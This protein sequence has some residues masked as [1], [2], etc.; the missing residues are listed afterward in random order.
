MIFH[1]IVYLDHWALQLFSESR[2]GGEGYQI[3]KFH[4]GGDVDEGPAAA[5]L[6]PEFLAGAFHSAL[7]PGLQRAVN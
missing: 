4:S 3:T 2:T 7:F 6:K 1:Q 5:D